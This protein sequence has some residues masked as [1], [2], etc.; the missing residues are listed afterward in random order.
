MNKEHGNLIPLSP[1]SI[2][3]PTMTMR[4]CKCLR[5][6]G[7][8]ELSVLTCRQLKFHLVM[9]IWLPWLIHISGQDLFSIPTGPKASTFLSFMTWFTLNWYNFV[10]GPKKIIPPCPVLDS[11]KNN[12][13]VIIRQADKG[14]SLVIQDRLDYLAEASRL[15]GDT[16]TKDELHI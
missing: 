3:A 12:D 6:C 1:Q 16:S 2:L 5:S 8:K 9:P 13:E 11:L 15:L 10:M 14:G 7:L 4:H